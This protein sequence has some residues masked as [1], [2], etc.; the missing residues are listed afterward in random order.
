MTSGYLNKAGATK[1]DDLS[2]FLTCLNNKIWHFTRVC[3]I[4][5]FMDG[6]RVDLPMSIIMNEAPHFEVAQRGMYSNWGGG[7]AGT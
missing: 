5:S 2:S 4:C 3:H 1:F 6:D 7:G